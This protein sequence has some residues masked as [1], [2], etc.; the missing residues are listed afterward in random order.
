VDVRY[1]WIVY[2]RIRVYSII[3]RLISSILSKIVFRE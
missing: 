2:D 1:S 3:T